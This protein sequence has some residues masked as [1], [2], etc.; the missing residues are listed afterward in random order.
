M[1]LKIL[2]SIILVSSVMLVAYKFSE[3]TPSLTVLSE[4]QQWK[5]SFNIKYDS[6]FENLYRLKLFTIKK[7]L[8][9]T[10]NANPSRSYTRGFN[11]FS[12]LTPE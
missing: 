8:V 9:E 1:S 11:Q 7:I 3:S 6:E 12:A 5:T 10:H 2:V 4:Y